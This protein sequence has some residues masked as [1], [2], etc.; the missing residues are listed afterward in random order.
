MKSTSSSASRSSGGREGL[1]ARIDQ[2]EADRRRH[3]EA[4]AEIDRVL[5]QIAEAV[6]KPVRGVARPRRG[7]FPMSAERSVLAF[8]RDRGRPATAEVN[9]HWRADGRRGTANVT[10]LKLLKAGLIRRVIDPAIRGSRYVAADAGAEGVTSSPAARA[11]RAICMG[12]AGRS[13]RA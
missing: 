8:I 13:P 1:V 6:G 12:P 7:R 2:L 3:V 11:D 9:A 5:A 4:M 10:L